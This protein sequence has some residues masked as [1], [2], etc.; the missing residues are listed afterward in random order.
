[1][2]V[3]DTLRVPA[4]RE[5]TG[6]PSRGKSEGGNPSSATNL[7]KIKPLCILME[8]EACAHPLP[9]RLRPATAADIM[10]DAVLWY[11]HWEG[12]QWAVVDEMRRPHDD[13]KAY[14][15]DG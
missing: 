4:D 3:Y 10:L 1:M 15:S 9:A 5:D 12:K 6:R 7:R 13:C 2:V 8:E 11:P 14:E